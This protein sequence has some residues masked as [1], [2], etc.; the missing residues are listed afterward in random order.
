[1]ILL[2]F[3]SQIEGTKYFELTYNFVSYIFIRMCTLIQRSALIGTKASTN[4]C[5][6]NLTSVMF[7]TKCRKNA[8]L[9]TL[10]DAKLLQQLPN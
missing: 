8:K 4:P 6:G 2:F 5:D 7:C 3:L 10:I 1:M 9:C